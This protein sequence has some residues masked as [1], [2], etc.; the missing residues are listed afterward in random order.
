MR[1]PGRPRSNRYAAI[2]TMIWLASWLAGCASSP[3][4]ASPAVG[5]ESAPA[6]AAPRP[7]QQKTIVVGI[8][9]DVQGFSL[10]AGDTTA[11]GWQS[12]QE[13][14]AAGLVTSDHDAH[15]P[16]GRLATKAPNFDDGSMSILPDG[17]MKTVYPLRSGV[18]WQ[19][20]APFTAADMMFS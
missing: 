8:S 9:T 12:A 19:D 17:R 15:T 13:I 3:Q 2:A 6:T 16:T 18:T 4:A 20:G 1:D 14:V 11:G 5:Q 10:L 7:A